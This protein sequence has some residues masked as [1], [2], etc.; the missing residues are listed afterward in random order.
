LLF[1]IW[2]EEDKKKKK[3]LGVLNVD[4]LC[5]PVLAGYLILIFLL[6]A[7]G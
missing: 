5:V 2:R 3:K 6:L 1:F 4:Y 7:V